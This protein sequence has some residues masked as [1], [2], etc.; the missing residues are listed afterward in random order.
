MTS[1]LCENLEAIEGYHKAIGA[2]AEWEKVQE[3]H[4]YTTIQKL[5]KVILN[6]PVSKIGV[7]EIRKADG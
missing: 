2:P 3:I 6:R 4:K 1:Y 5:D 7:S